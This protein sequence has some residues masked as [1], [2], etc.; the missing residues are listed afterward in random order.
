MP[1]NVP[2]SLTAAKLAPALLAGC[3]VVLKPA[4]ETPLN[5]IAL[6]EI[7]TEAGLP[8]GVLERHPRRPRRSA[9]RS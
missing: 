9:R 3:T 4:E 1:W 8:E 5:A 7:L 6:S 2:F